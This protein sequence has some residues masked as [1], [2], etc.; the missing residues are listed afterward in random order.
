M[1][2]DIIAFIIS[3]LLLCVLYNIFKHSKH[4]C[5]KSMEYMFVYGSAPIFF[6]VKCIM[7]QYQNYISCV[8]GI[9]VVSLILLLAI[10]KNDK[11][12]DKDN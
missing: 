9:L 6:M 11:K 5:P 4:F 7:S 10:Q 8:I 1:K 2:Q 3:L 12:T